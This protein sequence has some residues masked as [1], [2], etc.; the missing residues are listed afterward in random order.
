MN[1]PCS[2]DVDSGCCATWDDY[3]PETQTAAIEY[4]SLVLWAATG[5]RFGLCEITVRPCGRVKGTSMPPWGWGSFWL[6]GV[7]YP[8]IGEDGLWRNCGCHGFCNCRPQCEAYLPG[9]VDSVTE[10]LVDGVVV[11]PS[12]Y[13]VQDHSWLVRTEGDCWPHCPDLSIGEAFEVTYVRGQAVPS[14]LLNAAGT[15]ACEFAKACAGEP[16]RLPGRLAVIARQGVTASFVDVDRL[17]DRGMTGLVEVDQVVAALNPTRLHARPRVM[18]PDRPI[19]RTVTTPTA[20]TS[21]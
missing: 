5:R 21:S 4:A 11:D 9:P 12:Q 17:F 6:G 10:V 18:S 3:P 16:C 2:W 14:P 13:E 1:G 20:M 15:L 19:P 8:F 7:W